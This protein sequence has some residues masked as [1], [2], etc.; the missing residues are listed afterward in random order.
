MSRFAAILSGG[1]GERFWPASTP[2]RPK[3]FLPLLGRRSMLRETLERLLPLFAPERILVVTSAAL[4]VAAAR[5]CPE[6]PPG[7]VIGEPRSRNT[8]AAAGVAACAALAR[9]G[10]EAALALLP[11]DH[12]VRD[13]AAF[14]ETL[15]RAFRVAE[16]GAWLVTLGIRPDR[17]ESGYGYITRGEV[18]EGGAYRI[19]AFHEKPDA[20]RARELVNEGKSYWNAGMFVTRAETLIGEIERHAPELGSLLAALRAAGW[21][22]DKASA[23]GA[24]GAALREL[25]ARA[26]SI[27]FDHAVMERTRAGVVL[28]AEEMGWDDVGSWE[29]MARFRQR[30]AAGNVVHGVGRLAEARDNILFAEAGRITVIGASNLVVVRTG[31]ETFVCARD[32]LPELKELLRGLNGDGGQRAPRADAR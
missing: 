2:E 26:P 9:A 18:L 19:E 10:A 32:K 7:N 13:A 25:Y 14:R 24:E 5:E 12:I 30:D 28:P 1:V 17:V 4:S 3:Q 22:P 23:D 16:D 20:E 11:A 21:P 29:A 8:A 15:K 31:E 27:S 6:L